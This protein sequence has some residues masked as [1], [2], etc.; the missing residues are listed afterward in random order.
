MHRWRRAATVALIAL[1][2]VAAYAQPALRLVPAPSVVER[3]AGCDL[4]ASSLLR[5]PV[6]LDAGAFEE[7]QWRWQALGIGSL[8]SGPAS[9]A[10][11]AVVHDGSLA[12][13]AYRLAIDRKRAVVWSSDA[14]GAFYGIVTL[15]QMAQRSN[16]GWV[17]PCA[18]IEDRPKLR[19]RILSDDVSR[20]PL[21]TMRYFKER[22]RTIAAFKMNGY[23]P[24]MENAFVDPSNPLPSPLD[25]I[26]P[27]QLRALAVYAARYHVTLIPEQQTFAH[28]HNALRVEQYASAAELP[29][30]FLL[31]PV[32][33]LSEA[34]LR[35]TI[36]AELAADPHPPFFHIGSDETST[37]GAGTTQAY[38]AQHGLLHAFA[39]HVDAMQKIVAPS[40]ARIMLWGDAV[41]KDSSIMPMLPRNAVIVNY[42]YTAQFDFSKSIARIASGG[43][44]QMVAPGASNWNE[45]YPKIDTAIPN[46]RNFI[47]AGKVAGV[48]GA[49]ETVWHDDGESLYEAT[50]YPVLYAAAQ[51]W[52]SRDVDPQ[53]FAASY[54][55]AF[56]GVDD[57]RYARDVRSL[58][59]VTNALET[60]E[61]DTT[62]AL[63][64][65]DPFDVP[66]QARMAKVDL[67]QVRLDVES[68]ERHLIDARPPLHA[69]AAFVTF[70][71]ARRLDALARK[72]QIGA[73]VRAMYADAV[74]NIDELNG[75]TLRDL[76][77]CRY[78]MW[79]L[80]DTYEEL[81]P[82]YERAWRY[83]SRDG[84][85]ASN[86]ERYHVSAQHAISDADALYRATYDGYV[87][88]K[89]LPS[90]D[91]VIGR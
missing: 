55:S 19:W 9:K 10:T 14:D 77:W 11:I 72:F 3:V 5:A 61:Y 21:P 85:L 20:G 44:D 75:P 43:F 15:A 59:A 71:A 16:A 22:V 52:E 81:A 87:R 67:R 1:A 70:L 29:H 33:P 13:Q 41:D 6:G 7:L 28:M 69:N 42:Q 8:A 84:H 25:G 31:S 64:W 35:S 78:W 48:L 18:R 32:D 40:G 62:N 39:D 68:V 63:F 58:A 4:P 46:A 23:S 30:G 86:L 38:V 45:I 79:E 37:L 17:V 65:T 54:P 91:T 27:S 36:D 73:E 57:P 90:F 88:G 24:Y 66:A 12:P 80:R 82:L 49:F 50:W 2:P 53:T 56:F 60:S 47:G 51:A 26:T 76:Y 83:E 34:Y 74:A 89:T